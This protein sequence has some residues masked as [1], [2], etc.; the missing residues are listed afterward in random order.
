MIAEKA[1]LGTFLK[2]NHLLDDTMI[3]PEHF[4]EGRHRLLLP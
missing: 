1:L 2:G 4:E 3:K